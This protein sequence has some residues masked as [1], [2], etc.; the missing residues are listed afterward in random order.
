L[1]PQKKGNFLG[2]LLNFQGNHR[3]SRA[4]QLAK[5]TFPKA[6]AAVTCVA[7][8]GL[9]QP[10]AVGQGHPTKPFEGLRKQ[11]TPYQ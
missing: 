11:H 8:A 7:F 2:S 9:E 3:K 1:I 6:A 10:E 4:W 5:G